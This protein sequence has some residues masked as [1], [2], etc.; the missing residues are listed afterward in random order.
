MST[1]SVSSDTAEPELAR[2]RTFGGEGVEVDREIRR[3]DLRDYDDRF[4][5]IAD[6]IWDAAVDCGFFQIVNHGVDQAVVDAAFDWTE[7][8]FALPTAVKERRPMQPGTNSGW[9]YR[10]QV[11]PSTGTKDEKET[12]QITVPRMEP[13]D[14]WPTDEEFPGFREA[15]LA[16]ER[17]NHALGMRVLRCFA[18]KLGFPADFFTERHD[19]ASPHFQSTL[20]LLHY[21]PMDALP[22]EALAADGGPAHWRAGAHT[23]YDCLTLLHQLPGQHGLQVCPGRE[24]S[25]LAWTSVEPATGVVTCNIGDM[26]TR[27]SDDLLPSTLHRVRMPRP[28]EY[29]GPRYSMAYFCQADGD[30][31]IQGPQ[32]RYEPVTAADF[33]QQR[34][35]ANFA[36]ESKT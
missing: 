4:E 23:D 11:R 12:Y 30:A 25:E 34:I 33:L 22:V 31:V 16:F 1:P 19:L 5:A 18:H 6:E 8:F 2:E 20:R 29:D 3:I 27:W 32:R 24:A 9:E 21:L 35:A 13:L 26:L 17:S 36:G 7:R 14:L 28:G 10:S 15:M